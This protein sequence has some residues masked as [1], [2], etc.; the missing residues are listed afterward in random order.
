MS[1]SDFR[2]AGTGFAAVLF[3]FSFT[4][5]E[6]VAADLESDFDRDSDFR[7]D[8]LPEGAGAEVP[9]VVGRRNRTPPQRIERHAGKSAGIASFSIAFFT[10][11]SFSAVFSVVARDRSGADVFRFLGVF[12]FEPSSEESMEGR[13]TGRFLKK[14]VT[15]K[16][17]K[18]KSRGQLP[19]GTR[20]GRMARSRLGVR[21][22]F[23]L[24]PTIAD[25]ICNRAIGVNPSPARSPAKSSVNMRRYRPAVS[26]NFLGNAESVIVPVFLKMPR[27]PPV[28]AS[29]SDAGWNRQSEDNGSD[30]S[31]EESER[32]CAAYA[33][34]AICIDGNFGFFE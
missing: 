20:A 11:F 19:A 13:F 1:T 25:S 6:R 30:D 17:R 14:A 15:I 22:E 5:R 32:M 24:V 27:T 3:S 10:V 29:T 8:P 26:E 18:N 2:S 21:F 33:D 28:T 31:D 7:R 16:N 12:L 23:R 34:K 4:C 9:W